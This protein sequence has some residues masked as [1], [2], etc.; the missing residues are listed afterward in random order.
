[1]EQYVRIRNTSP[2]EPFIGK[3]DGEYITIPTETE[4]ILPWDVMVVWMGDPAIENTDRHQE[5][6]EVFNRLCMMHHAA[7]L[8]GNDLSLLPPLE[9]Y[10][11]DGER[12]ITVLDDPEGVSLVPSADDNTDVGK[13]QR[14]IERLQARVEEKLGGLVD[15]PTDA[16]DNDGPRSRPPGEIAAEIAAEDAVLNGETAETADPDDDELAIPEDTPAKIPV[17]KAT[18]GKAPARKSPVKAPPGKPRRT[19]GTAGSRA[20]SRQK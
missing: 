10:T 18:P 5:R 20:A 13:L 12:I 15:A 19:A 8:T 3:Y 1:M 14:Q 11:E 9:A 16:P 17:G 7:T 6:S 4:R 2:D